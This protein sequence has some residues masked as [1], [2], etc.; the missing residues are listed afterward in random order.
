MTSTII[1]DVRTK[2]ALPYGG[3]PYNLIAKHYEQTDPALIAEHKYTDPYG[4]DPKDD[5]DNYVRAEI[6]D[7]SPDVP[8]FES[9]HARRDSSLSR[10]QL[11][12]RY[13]ATRGSRPELPRH[14]ELFIGFV[15]NDPR[16]ALLEPRMDQVRGFMSAQAANLTVR[17]GDNDDNGETER[18]WTGQSISYGMKYVQD[19]VKKNTKIFTTEKDGRPFS[20]NL[21]LD[22]PTWGINQG[23]IRKSTMEAGD[24]TIDMSHSD[25]KDYGEYI[26]GGGFVNLGTKGKDSGKF[27]TAI[28]NPWVNTQLEGDMSDQYGNHVRQTNTPQNQSGFAVKNVQNDQSYYDSYNAPK[29]TKKNLAASMALAAKNNKNRKDTQ[30][31]SLMNDQADNFMNNGNLK[32]SQNISHIYRNVQEDQERQYNEHNS[33]AINSG[34]QMQQNLG[35][36]SKLTDNSNDKMMHHANKINNISMIAKGLKEGSASSKR[37]I[38][39]HVQSNFNVGFASDNSNNVTKQGQQSSDFNRVTKMAD[40]TQSPL[41]KNELSDGVTVQQY[42]QSKPYHGEERV[43]KG[44]FGHETT[45]W[46]DSTQTW[47]TKN[48]VMPGNENKMRYGNESL[49]STDWKHHNE[50]FIK[51]GK[52]PELE[53][54]MRNHGLDP[55]NWQHQQ[56][57]LQGK[58]VQA[59]PSN[60][61]NVGQHTYNP[62]EF[63]NEYAQLVAGKNQ[64]LSSRRSAGNDPT[65]LGM[66][67]YEQFGADYE[68]PTGAIKVGP[69]SLKTWDRGDSS[70]EDTLGDF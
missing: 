19:Q 16:G 9:D 68:A 4:S 5:Y 59:S 57:F 44:Q 63:N 8:Y 49:S 41:F 50:T 25:G 13:N 26:S 65:E 33:N 70:M 48:Q 18:P 56:E 62:N 67:A 7:W 20:R 15:E 23:K 64:S 40:Y 60:F 1:S 69:K 47:L 31:D 34:L 52:N 11:N 22:A 42:T 58:G 53:Q 3:I 61:M 36:V 17:M 21:V 14:P 12:L 29:A 43:R 24:E 39:N 32:P 2:N 28:T 37:K 30:H 46:D 27:S 10:S 51:H 6:V 35:K 54:R 38:Q 55:T 66:D 45:V